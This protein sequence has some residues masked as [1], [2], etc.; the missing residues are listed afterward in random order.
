MNNN[1]QELIKKIYYD[2]S[3]GLNLK[4]TYT[5]AKKQDPT[6]T[7]KDV[8]DFV[9]S[10]ENKNIFDKTVKIDKMLPI[11]SHPG[12]YSADITF[13]DQYKKFNGGNIGLLTIINI[14]TKKG[15]A[16]PIKSKHANEIYPPLVNSRFANLSSKRARQSNN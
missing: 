8:K 7:F 3:L 6:I 10:T 14:N 9:A 5:N 1:K 12:S 16:Y 15:F 2:P 4:R 13:Y 11:V